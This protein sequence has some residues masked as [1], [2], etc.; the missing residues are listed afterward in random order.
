MVAKQMNMHFASERTSPRRLLRSDPEDRRLGVQSRLLGALGSARLGPVLLELAAEDFEASEVFG[1]RLDEQGEPDMLVS[2]GLRGF[3]ARRAM[4]YLDRFATLDPIIETIRT[5]AREDCVTA[6]SF[7][8]RDI[9]DESYRGRCFDHAG[10]VEKVSCFQRRGSSIFVLAFYR[11][12][13]EFRS[14]GPIVELAELALPVLQRHSEMLEGEV[15]LSLAQ[16]LERRLAMH[17]P[18]LT[19]RERGVCARTLAGMTAEAIALE[20]GI[21]RTSVLTYRRRAY[22]RYGVSSAGQFIENI[23]G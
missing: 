19:D 7:R 8:S 3:A 10:L 20:L 18:S 9:A 4:L 2:H 23:L 5:R 1:F 11:T 12:E 13:A 21:G 22:E 15:G 14:L 6:A 17:F 16:R